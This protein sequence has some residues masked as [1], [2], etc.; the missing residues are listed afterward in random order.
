MKRCEQQMNDVTPKLEECEGFA[1]VTL[2]KQKADFEAQI[3]E[4]TT[5]SEFDERG[6]EISVSA[7]DKAIR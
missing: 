4:L 7:A 5:K 3:A 1:K 6:E 2:Q